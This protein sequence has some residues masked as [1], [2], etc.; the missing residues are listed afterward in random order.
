MRV[1]KPFTT[2]Y[3]IFA[4]LICQFAHSVHVRSM[5]GNSKRKFHYHIS[6][7]VGENLARY[8]QWRVYFRAVGAQ[9]DLSFYA[10]LCFYLFSFCFLGAVHALHG[11]KRRLASSGKRRFR[12]RRVWSRA[13]MRKRRKRKKARGIFKGRGR[14][15][16]PYEIPTMILALTL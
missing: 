10:F 1:Q 15:S 9:S 5:R 13:V 12:A 8:L 2:A 7:G 4:I 16:P 3:R 11:E 14:P 6:S